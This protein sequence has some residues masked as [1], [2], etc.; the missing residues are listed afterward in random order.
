MVQIE[1]EEDDPL[2]EPE[3]AQSTSDSS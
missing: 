1:E 3:L 2:P